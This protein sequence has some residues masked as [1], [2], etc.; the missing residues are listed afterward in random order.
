MNY[1]KQVLEETIY[2]DTNSGINEFQQ[3]INLPKHVYGHCATN[4][5]I[6]L[7]GTDEFEAAIIMGGYE[8]DNRMD[9][10]STNK[11]YVFCQANDQINSAVCNDTKVGDS[12]W[13]TFPDMKSSLYGFKGFGHTYCTQFNDD[14]LCDGICL[15]ATGSFTKTSEFFPL[16]RCAETGKDCEWMDSLG[17]N[18]L[19]ITVDKFQHGIGGMTNLNNIPTLFLPLHDGSGNQWMDVLEFKH[20]D[21]NGNLVDQWVSREIWNSHRESF[22]TIS[23]PIEFLC[24]QTTTQPTTDTTSTTQPTTDTTSSHTKTTG[25]TTQGNYASQMCGKL[26]F[27]IVGINMFFLII[28]NSI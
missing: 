24:S 20:Q 8:G 28:T 12:S 25:S 7:S 16:T 2:F 14:D 4:I 23:V 6:P 11:A 5:K 9:V 13:S 19:N 27:F 1:E 3:G 15:M 21:E 18:P 26:S 17:G 10:I 22:S